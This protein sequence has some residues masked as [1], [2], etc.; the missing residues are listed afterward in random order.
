MELELLVFHGRNF[1]HRDLKPEN[2]VI[3]R[4]DPS[5]VYLIDFGLA[6]YYRDAQGKHIPMVSDKGLI[7]TARYASIN[8]MQGNEQSRKDDLEAIGYLLVYFLEGRLPWMNI[9][10]ANREEKYQKV[11]DKKKSVSVAMLC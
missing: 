2:F 4:T 8:S 9:A 7:G 11:L 1:I 6:K 10:V 3:G 5:V